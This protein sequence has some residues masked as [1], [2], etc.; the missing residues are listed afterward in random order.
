MVSLI[1]KEYGFDEVTIAAGI[2]HDVLEDTDITRD[3]LAEALGEDVAKIVDGV[4]E[5]MALEWEI[6]KEEY[7]KSVGAA[8]EST[9]AVSIA[10]KIHNA[11]SVIHDYQE[12]GKDVWKVFNRGKDKKLWF[13]NLIY[14]EVS[15]TWQHPI[16][17]RYRMAIDMMEKL[18]E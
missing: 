8:D 2:T 17:D 9:K 1:L 4:S 14:S 5:D 6:R 11:E 16:M 7:A 15:K 12:K 18:E 3:V 13:E 10:D